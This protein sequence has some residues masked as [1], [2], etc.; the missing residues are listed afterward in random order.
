M[1]L[2]EFI[3]KYDGKGIDWDNAYGFQC[4]DLYRQYT[5][6]CPQAGRRSY[7][8]DRTR[9]LRPYRRLHRSRYQQFHLVRP[10]LSLGISLSFAEAYLLRGVGVVAPQ[11]PSHAL[12]GP[13]RDTNRPRQSEDRLGGRL[14]R[15]GGSSG[16]ILPKRH[17]E[18][19][20]RGEDRSGGAEDSSERDV[21]VPPSPG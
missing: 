16:P 9:P 5:R 2:Q 12:R 10:K 13:P 14:G 6:Q 18:G 17:E 1:T 8:G 21:E 3:A 7:L 11:G 15:H 20:R 19:Y 4:M